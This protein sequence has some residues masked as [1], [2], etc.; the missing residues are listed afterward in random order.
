MRCNGYLKGKDGFEG[1]IL[2]IVHAVTCVEVPNQEPFLIVMHQACYY[3]QKE[4]D[5]N[6]KNMDRNHFADRAC[7]GCAGVAGRARALAYL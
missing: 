6:E 4:Q 1:P 3:E 2:P 5:E 7:G